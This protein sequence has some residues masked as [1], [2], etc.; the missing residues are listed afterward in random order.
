MTAV[1]FLPLRGAGAANQRYGSG[2]AAASFLDRGQELE[3]EVA[4]LDQ[5]R[6]DPAAHRREVLVARRAVAERLLLELVAALVGHLERVLGARFWVGP[7]PEVVAA[8]PDEGTAFGDIVID[9]VGIEAT[10]SVASAQVRPGG[11]ILHIG[12]GSARGG[13]DL[14][15]MTLQEI[16]LI[17]TYT[18]T[19]QDFRDTA[20]A[21]FD[22]R[23]GPLTWTESRPLKDGA[24]AFADIRAGRV[25]APKIILKPDPSAAC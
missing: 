15:R 1:W 6:S 21:M 11:A 12:L 20:R 19:A 17:G 25:S 9:A 22:G 16:T 14:R 5:H 4:E 24:V 23:L 7:A 3:P 2:V 13:L 8:P 18:Y 10:R